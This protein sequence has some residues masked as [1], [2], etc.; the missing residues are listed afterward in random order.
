[1]AINFQSLQIGTRDDIKPGAETFVQ[2]RYSFLSLFYF[3]LEG[4]F[5]IFKTV[6]QQFKS[7]SQELQALISRVQFEL[8]EYGFNLAPAAGGGQELMLVSETGE[9]SVGTDKGVVYSIQF[10]KPV[11]GQDQA[12][13]IG[14]A[15]SAVS[16]LAVEE[17]KLEPNADNTT[18]PTN[19]DTEQVSSEQMKNRFLMIRVNFDDTLI[20]GKP[21]KP[22]APTAPVKPEGYVPANK[23][24]NTDQPP[25][26]EGAKAEQKVADAEEKTKAEQDDRISSFKEYDQ[27]LKEY[28]EQT[29]IYELGLTRFEDEEIAFQQKVKEGE[30]RVTALNERFGPWFY[31]ISGTNLETLKIDR[32]QLIQPLPPSLDSPLVPLNQL[33]PRPNINFGPAGSPELENQSPAET[34]PEKKPPGAVP[35]STKPEGDGAKDGA[36]QSDKG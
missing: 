1:M 30:K 36:K 8:Q 3:L 28:E 26:P 25:L 32:Q 10:G 23:N 27:L 4:D 24:S 31:V 18:D 16:G 17:S 19:Q 22:T 12:I 15:S 9:M 35:D 34:A 2:G 11:S 13:E 6:I 5:L 21:V 33:P 20:A 14:G 29:A 7:N